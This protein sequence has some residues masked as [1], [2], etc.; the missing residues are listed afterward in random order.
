LNVWGRTITAEAASGTTLR[1][2]GRGGQLLK[3]VNASS[4]SY[5][6]SGNEGYVRVEAIGENGSKGWSQPFFVSWQ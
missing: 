4:G 5:Q 1:F 3:A 6:V 2:I